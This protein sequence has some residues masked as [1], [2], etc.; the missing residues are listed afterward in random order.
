[1]PPREKKRRASAIQDDITNNTQPTVASSSSSS[2][3]V[4][5]DSSLLQQL[6]DKLETLEAESK[7]AIG[8]SK[9]EQSWRAKCDAQQKVIDA[10]RADNARM[11][12]L[13]TESGSIPPLAVKMSTVYKLVEAELNAAK[14]QLSS[15]EG[16]LSKGDSR[17]T[18][19]VSTDLFEKKL[20]VFSTLSALTITPRF[21]NS[22]LDAFLGPIGI[23][24]LT[25]LHPESKALI[26]FQLDFIRSDTVTTNGTELTTSVEYSPGSNCNLLPDF[27]QKVINF[28]SDQCPMFLAKLTESLRNMDYQGSGDP[29]EALGEEKEVKDQINGEQRSSGK[30]ST[31]LPKTPAK[32]PT[33]ASESSMAMLGRLGGISIALSGIT[34]AASRRARELGVMSTPGAPNSSSAPLLSSSTPFDTRNS[35]APAP[36]PSGTA[37]R[38]GRKSSKTPTTS[39]AI[40]IPSQRKSLGGFQHSEGGVIRTSPVS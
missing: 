20:A 10:L 35:R 27:L 17:K 24:D 19:S 14:A 2:S 33:T 5:F 16:K 25:T 1:M 38:S 7:K 15:L 3:N 36:T 22:S 29:I 28:E 11:T 18:S 34:P 21:G 8:I 32:T 23:F 40:A 9:A 31:I 37:Q 6:K 4:E 30:I 13:L 12:A 26:Q 39:S